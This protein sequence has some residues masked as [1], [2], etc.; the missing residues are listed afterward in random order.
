MFK[1]T[2]K[3]IPGGDAETSVLWRMLIAKPGKV[4]PENG[5]GKKNQEVKCLRV[6][7][8]IGGGVSYIFPTGC[9]P[10]VN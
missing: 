7:D 8:S 9:K 2:K 5:A 4:S 3:Y 10:I 6:W 1:G